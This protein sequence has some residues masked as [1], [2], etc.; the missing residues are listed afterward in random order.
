[1]NTIKQ[2]LFY[3]WSHS[4]LKTG[5]NCFD[6]VTMAPNLKKCRDSSCGDFAVLKAQWR[7]NFEAIFFVGA[8]TMYARTLGGGGVQ[9]VQKILCSKF[10]LDHL[11]QLLFFCGG[12]HNVCTFFG[13]SGCSKNILLKINFG[14]F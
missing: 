2:G 3:S 14:P 9:V 6:D 4:Q 1:M 11:D 13:G 12:T 5:K 7:Q 8:Y 10:V